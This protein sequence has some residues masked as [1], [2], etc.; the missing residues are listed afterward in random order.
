MIIAFSLL[1]AVTQKFGYEA[2]VH[3]G[4]MNDFVNNAF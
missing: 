4:K 1:E 2:A 3:S